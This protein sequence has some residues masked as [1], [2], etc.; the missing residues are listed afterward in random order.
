MGS[1]VLRGVARE[2]HVRLQRLR[3]LLLQ[4]LLLHLL[5]LPPPL[6][7]GGGGG[8]DYEEFGGWTN[9]AWWQISPNC[10]QMRGTLTLQ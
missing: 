9:S 1:G 2:L 6:Q 8:D 3:P 5:L 10:S 4:Q 7:R